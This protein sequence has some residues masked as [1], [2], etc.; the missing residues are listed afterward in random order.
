MISLRQL[1][2]VAL[3]PA[4]F[5]SPVHWTLPG[6]D[7]SLH[8]TDLTKIQEGL[9][10]QLKA[11]VVDLGNIPGIQ[12]I[13]CLR[14]EGNDTAVDV[15]VLSSGP[16]NGAEAQI[17]RAGT[18]L[19]AG[20][21]HGCLET[22]PAAAAEGVDQ[23]VLSMD[24]PMQCTEETMQD[25]PRALLTGLAFLVDRMQAFQ[26]LNMTLYRGKA[27]DVPQASSLRQISQIAEPQALGSEQQRQT[28]TSL[29]D[30]GDEAEQKYPDQAAITSDDSLFAEKLLNSVHST[31]QKGIDTPAAE[32]EAEAP[33]HM[34][35]VSEMPQLSHSRR[36]QA[37]VPVCPSQRYVDVEGHCPIGCIPTNPCPGG[38]VPCTCLACDTSCSAC[39][40]NRTN[41]MACSADYC[42]LGPLPD[43]CGMPLQSY[44][45]GPTGDRNFGDQNGSQLDKYV[46]TL[47]N[48][49]VIPPQS[50]PSADFPEYLY[51]NS[52]HYD[53]H[54]KAEHG[55]NFLD[56]TFYVDYPDQ[57]IQNQIES[58]AGDPNIYHAPPP[59]QALPMGPAL[60][61]L[62]LNNNHTTL[63]INRDIATLLP[64]ESI[65]VGVYS[66]PFQVEK[67]YPGGAYWQFGT[68]YANAS[69]LGDGWVLNP[70]DFAY[71]EDGVFIFRPNVDGLVQTNGFHVEIALS[72]PAC[73][74][75]SGL[76]GG[77]EDDDGPINSGQSLDPE[78][79][80]ATGL[81]AEAR[82]GGPDPA[83]NVNGYPLFNYNASGSTS[84]SASAATSGSSLGPIALLSEPD[85]SITCTDCYVA[86]QQLEVLLNVVYEAELN[87]FAEVTTQV[88]VGFDTRLGV[89]IAV[90]NGTGAHA[91]TDFRGLA[92]NSILAQYN[93]F[94]LAV[95]LQPVVTANLSQQS[96]VSWATIQPTTVDT[97]IHTHFGFTYGYSY[98]WTTGPYVF[99]QQGTAPALTLQDNMIATTLDGFT[100]QAG[101]S[102]LLRNRLGIR[103]GLTGDTSLH[104]FNKA[105]DITMGMQLAPVAAPPDP[106]GDPLDGTSGT[107]I[108]L[109][110]CS[111]THSMTAIL[112]W[113]INN[114]LQSID[115]AAQ[116]STGQTFQGW[117]WQRSW[118]PFPMWSFGENRRRRLLGGSN[119]QAFR[120]P[121]ILTPYK[122]VASGCYC[123]YGTPGCPDLDI[124]LYVNNSQVAAKPIPLPTTPTT[125]PAR[126][127]N[128]L[129]VFISLPG[130]SDTALSTSQTQ[131]LQE[132]EST[133]AS[134]AFTTFQDRASYFITSLNAA[135]QA[136]SLPL[137]LTGLA[138][139]QDAQ[140]QSPVSSPPP[141]NADVAAASTPS[142]ASMQSASH[143]LPVG[144]II[145]IV[146]G[147]ALLLTLLV[148]S[149]CLCSWFFV[150]GGKQRRQSRNTEE[151]LP[152]HT[153]VPQTAAPT[154][155]FMPSKTSA[156]AGSAACPISQ[157][158]ASRPL[159]SATPMDTAAAPASHEKQYRDPD[160]SEWM[161]RTGPGSLHTSLTSN[162]NPSP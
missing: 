36:L 86:V 154:T 52:Y 92:G 70:K 156:K 120:D 80:N 6:L 97:G 7:P 144:A 21:E 8:A 162:N 113:G 159:E 27:A 53:Y 15:T 76:A 65:F 42:Q 136:S 35:H 33:R 28:E 18:R 102:W 31:A 20:A 66:A 49:T 160:Q 112:D 69:S 39:T 16:C 59:P 1:L 117:T 13:K 133:A 55:Q 96:S 62:C 45:E 58:T 123:P 111:Q 138:F 121:G 152:I 85:A 122:P 91:L 23:A 63:Q 19:L 71:G 50:N 119:Y 98:N 140:I 87:G 22:L 24:R 2:L 17:V 3:L 155:L 88:T 82:F 145:G 149:C 51:F 110:D 38:N 30:I 101:A 103:A 114:T 44:Q 137:T 67:V 107:H 100:K 109:T 108:S 141:P 83:E 157:D 127:G 77:L 130:V 90:S 146:I 12:E 105:Q 25:Q 142:G 99:T 34:D 78:Y 73:G 5:N 29:T 150:L 93:V 128:V 37:P 41:C 153:E 116:T 74:G 115:L 4:A 48:V 9:Q 79:V 147:G 32:V 143:T 161:L 54:L 151:S 47:L 60:R 43:T 81:A 68:K 95:S 26:R 135:T 57:I 89:S 104:T 75:S 148:S 11:G 124:D 118:A 125:N 158:M 106:Q 72:C 139:T 61:L 132:A 40:G 14:A 84:T 10:A 46:V 94:A 126:L 129:E 134:T 56:P 64:K 131:W